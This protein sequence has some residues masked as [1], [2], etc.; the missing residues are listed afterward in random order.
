[1]KE[2]NDGRLEKVRREAPGPDKAESA[3]KRLF[4]LS[5]DLFFF[6]KDKPEAAF[7]SLFR[8][9]NGNVHYV[10]FL[11]LQLIKHDASVL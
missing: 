4:M 9:E 11:I 10:I 2:E 5:W 7:C 8:V 6:V 1:M 3:E